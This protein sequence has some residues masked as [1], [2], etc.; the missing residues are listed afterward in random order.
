MA[1]VWLNGKEVGEIGLNAAVCGHFKVPLIMISGDQTA[2]AEATEL[3]GGVETAVV[4]RATSRM[5]AECLSPEA[6]QETIHAAAVR[7]VH[8][9]SAGEVSPPFRLEAPISLAI[10]FVQPEMADRAA[11]LPGAHRS[12]GRQVQFSADDMPAAYRLFQA[13]VALAK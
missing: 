11:L 3:L 1:N 7:A 13:T 8:R 9:L 6:A 2:C 10:Q 4:K 5:A 12:G